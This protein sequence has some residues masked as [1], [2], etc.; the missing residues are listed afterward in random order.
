MSSIGQQGSSLGSFPTSPPLYPHFNRPSGFWPCVKSCLV[1]GS[2]KYTTLGSSGTKLLLPSWLLGFCHEERET[3]FLL[4]WLFHLTPPRAVHLV[5]PTDLARPRRGSKNQLT[6]SSFKSQLTAFY[7]K[8]T[9]NPQPI[10]SGYDI[11]HIPSRGF[12]YDIC[13]CH[14][15]PVPAWRPA[16]NVGTYPCTKLNSSKPNLTER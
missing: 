11:I 15:L 8:I 6:S 2:D 16:L 1:G 13:D 7:S 4:C 5:D 14:I 10:A 3:Q 12:Y 9:Q